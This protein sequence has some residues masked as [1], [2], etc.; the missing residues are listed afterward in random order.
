MRGQSR[1]YSHYASTLCFTRCAI[2]DAAIGYALAFDRAGGPAPFSATRQGAVLRQ[3]KAIR[4]VEGERLRAPSGGRSA[5]LVENS[6]EFPASAVEPRF[7]GLRADPEHR[8][9]LRIAQLFD[10]AQ[11]ERLLHARGEFRDR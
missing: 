10:G 2:A 8:R 7:N 1:P 9:G 11:K 4:P 5:F 6:R 3:T